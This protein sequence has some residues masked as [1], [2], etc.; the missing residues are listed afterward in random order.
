MK[1]SE[2]LS[3]YIEKSGFSLGELS[4]RLKNKNLK[5]D[6]SYLS[7]LKN[8][9]KPPASDELNRSIAE[10]TGGD[11]KTLI[12]AAHLEKIPKDMKDFFLSFD[13]SV[14]AAAVELEKK[15][16]GFLRGQI[17]ISPEIRESM[18]FQ[19]L[20]THM[21]FWG[22]Q[23]PDFMDQTENNINKI[24]HSSKES[25]LYKSFFNYAKGT[26][27][28]CHCPSEDQVGIRSTILMAFT[29]FELRL[30]EVLLKAIQINGTSSGVGMN[31]LKDLPL[32]TKLRNPLE[33]YLGYDISREAFSIDLWECIDLNTKIAF[34]EV[35]EIISRDKANYVLGTIDA[36]I[37]SLN[38]HAKQKGID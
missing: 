3:E 2:L 33:Q 37:V 15:F 35:Q 6:R 16:P 12:W 5:A 34:N 22:Y 31:Y 10:I 28:S 30:N 14:I 21:E 17:E 19:R 4:L 27:N 23:L 18:E 38:K 1:Y 7:K 8:G 20:K 25:I 13:G 29:S 32:N 24:E 11:P 9:A 36:A 26:L